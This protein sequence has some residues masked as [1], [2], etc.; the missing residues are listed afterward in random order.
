MYE[1]T[2][3]LAKKILPTTFIAKNEGFMRGVVSLFYRGKKHQ[4]NLCGFKMSKFITLSNRTGLCPKCGSLPRTRRLYAL[5]EEK[6]G[7]HSK[8]TLHFSPPK[9]MADKLRANFSGTYITTDFMD[10]FN[11]DKQ[12]D[13]TNISEADNTYNVIICY[14]VLEHIEQ[15]HLAMAE[16]Y[17]ILDEEGICFIQT[18]F[19]TGNIYEDFSIVSETDRLAHFGQEDHVRIYSAKGLQERLEKVGFVVEPLVFEETE[20]HYFGFNQEEVVLLARKVGSSI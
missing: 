11:A 7:F 1:I 3:K 20:N 19:K 16:L 18:P 5:I 6:T 10:E 2:K 17:R 15:D 13:I 8:N 9:I 14:H 4:C 12:L